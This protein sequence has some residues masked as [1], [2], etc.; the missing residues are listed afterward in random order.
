[1]DVYVSHLAA[2]KDHHQITATED[3]RTAQ[4]LKLLSRGA[5]LDEATLA[6]LALQKLHKPLGQSVGIGGELDGAQLA[7]LVV[8]LAAQHPDGAALLRQLP[9]PLAELCSS[10]DRQPLLC[11]RL[12]VMRAVFPARFRR[13]LFGA[14]LALAIVRSGNLRGLS[15]PGLFVAALARSIGL[16]HLPEAFMAREAQHSAEAQRQFESHPVVSREMI[17]RSI[18]PVTAEAILNQ[19]ERLDGSGFPRGSRAGTPS[20]EAQLLGLADWIAWLC[21]ERVEAGA[22]RIAH[23]LQPLRLFR[24]FWSGAI[25]NAACEMI[26]VIG[27]SCPPLVSENERPAWLAA[28][29]ARHQQT[30]RQLTA[31]LEE[32]GAAT[33]EDPSHG[34]HQRRCLLQMLNRIN[35][36][37]GLLSPEYERWIDHVRAQQL[38]VAYAEMDEV[39]LQLCC[40]E[41]L[42]QRTRLLCGAPEG[43]EVAA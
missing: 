28:L 37:S 20:P 13:T 10:L 23:A 15:L 29:L 43:E 26:L 39:Y 11:Q 14:L 6:R 27:G 18:D 41:P 4:G 19:H 9:L 8:E 35:T 38:S 7:T 42:L 2:L 1:M 16:L 33:D 24:L 36:S 30:G 12:T 5:R 3:I 40:L 17:R 32:L 21:L 25:F 31:L 22:G 34:Q